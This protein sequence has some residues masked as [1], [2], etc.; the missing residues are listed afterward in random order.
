MDVTLIVMHESPTHDELVELL[1]PVWAEALGTSV[2]RGSDF[3]ALGGTSLAAV[4][5]ATAVAA[6]YERYD[7]IGAQ[8]LEAVF[9]SPTLDDMATAL[10][11]FVDERSGE[12]R[13][14]SSSPL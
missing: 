4:L 7:D 9:A 12:P 10:K 5:I 11:T 14:A 6:R 1:I 2:G 3:L 13:A 8:A